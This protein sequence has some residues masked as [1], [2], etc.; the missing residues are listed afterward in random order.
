M[1]TEKIGL[2]LWRLFEGER[3]PD[4]ATRMFA[5]RADGTVGVR[6]RLEEEFAEA[7]GKRAV[8][9]RAPLEVE[10]WRVGEGAPL[11]E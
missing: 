4:S 11:A 10:V 9:E 3:A 7:I 8:F 1:H 2:N 6:T 5:R